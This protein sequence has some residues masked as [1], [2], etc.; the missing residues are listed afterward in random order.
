MP[1]TDTQE[2][3]KPVIAAPAPIDGEVV[4]DGIALDAARIIDDLFAQGH[5]SRAQRSSKVQIAVRDAIYR[6][7]QAVEIDFVDGDDNSESS[8]A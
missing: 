7:F 4:L 3:K 1:D 8:A 6:A 2:T 5:K